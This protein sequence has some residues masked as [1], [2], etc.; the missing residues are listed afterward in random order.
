[1]LCPSETNSI[2]KSLTGSSYVVGCIHVGKATGALVGT[3][4]NLT[5]LGCMQ[6]ADGIA[7]GTGALVGNSSVKFGKFMYNYYDVELSPGTNAVGTTTDK[8]DYDDYIRGAKSHILKAKNDY[9]IGADVDISKLN[10]NMKKEMYGMAPW[11]ALNLGIVEY[12]GT[13]IGAVY[14][15]NL[16]YEQSAVGYIHRYPILK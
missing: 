5:M 12:N 2:A 6:A 10:A 11:K 14:P 8:Y 4:D 9:M 7:N 3:A 1:M 15:C 13:T 16:R